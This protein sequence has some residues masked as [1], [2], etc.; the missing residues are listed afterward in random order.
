MSW[1]KRYADKLCNADEAVSRIEKGKHIFLS[2]GAAEPLTLVDGLV[3]AASRFEGNTIV[4]LMTLGP[5]PYVEKRFE[6]SF[7]HN[8]FFIGA[9]VRKA[10]HEGRADYTPVFLSQIPDLIR[11]GRMQVDVALIHTTPPD[12]Y[13]FV[14]LGVSVDI[15]LAAVETAELVIA[16]VNP[17]MPTLQGAGYVPMSRID[18]LVE[19]EVDLL[20]HAPEEIDE[21]ALEIGRNVASLIEDESTLQMGIGQVPDAVLKAL[22]DKKDLGLWTEMFSDG[23]LE[24]L[25]NGNITGKYKTIHPGKIS[26]SFT[27]GTKRLYRLLDRNPLFTFHP[28]DL[29]NDPINIARQ[30]KMVAI[31]SALQIDLTGQ[32]CADSI[33]TKFYS[34]I[35]GQ[36]DF[37][38]G[39]SMGAGGKPII[40]FRSTAKE[41]SISRIAA[42]LDQG[43]GVV[44]SRG[45]VRYVVTEY[46]IADLLGTSVRQ[47]AMSLIS[48]AHP[49]FRAE[50]MSAAKERHYVFFDQVSPRASYPRRWE[51]AL[52]P[53]DGKQVLIR[54][55]RL[56]DEEKVQDLLYSLSEETIYKRFMGRY[57]ASRSDIQN[58]LDVDYEDSMALVVQVT[59]GDHEPEL[60]GVAQYFADPATRSAE[61]AFM[62]RDDWQRKGLGTALFDHLIRIARE[63][64]I[65]EFTA[66]TFVTNRGMLR[67]FHASGLRVQASMDGDLYHLR[68]RLGTLGE[69]RRM[70]RAA[71][72]RAVK[73]SL[74]RPFQRTIDEAQPGSDS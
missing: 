42:V 12:D 57:R 52:D 7:R 32:V 55:S 44:T 18:A 59:D 8:A 65:T 3:A 21:T 17:R 38:R 36:V 6:Q 11:S 13:G 43:A 66:E 47:R 67:V 24:L 56:V 4:H 58:L 71:I 53:I 45:D 31:N 10:V 51:L 64:S 48:I 28:S 74:P 9:N 70:A 20:E 50:L 14:N 41:G 5:A 22:G 61:V 46:G 15:V 34:G 73:G 39:A 19:S 26:S 37:I 60:V 35:G 25:E 2:S 16:Q 27:F 49:S 30:H 54:P 69:T 1:R 62:I 63:N 72:Q 68:M 40:A 29:I 33:G 23:V